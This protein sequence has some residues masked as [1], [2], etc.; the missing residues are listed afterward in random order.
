MGG[1]EYLIHDIL[2]V[3]SRLVKCVWP[4]DGEMSDSLW[5]RGSARISEGG[6]KDIGGGKAGQ[7]TQ[8]N[9]VGLVIDCC[10]ANNPRI[11]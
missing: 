9:L 10:M 8:R 3:K 1:E 2:K 6:M 7:I 5:A 11:W 4:Q